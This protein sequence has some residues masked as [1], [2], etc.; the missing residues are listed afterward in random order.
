M[1]SFLH[2]VVERLFAFCR[3]WKAGIMRWLV[4]H[5]DR[6]R[7]VIADKLCLLELFGLLLEEGADLVGELGEI[8]LAVEID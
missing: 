7:L 4:I 5:H 3:L 8:G 1:F 2:E 6:L